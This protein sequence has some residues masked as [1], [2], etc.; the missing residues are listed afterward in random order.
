MLDATVDRGDPLPD[1]S[2][3]T[4]IS[5]LAARMNAMLCSD[6]SLNNDDIP[7]L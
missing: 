6:A 3:S 1:G 7:S 2:S 4:V 5:P